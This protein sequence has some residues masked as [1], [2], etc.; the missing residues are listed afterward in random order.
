MLVAIYNAWDFEH[1]RK[2]V[3]NIKQCVDQVIIVWSRYS[4]FGVVGTFNPDLF[5]DCVCVQ[6]E[7]RGGA[8]YQKEMAKRNYGLER[9]RKMKADYFIMMD[10]DEF[11]HPDEVTKWY[12]YI[13]K[14]NLAGLVCKTKVYFKEPTLTIGDDTTYVTFIH[15]VN[16]KL[17]FNGNN[18]YPFT[19][20]DDIIRID[21]TRR[22]NINT[23]VELVDCYMH[24]YSWVRQDYQTKA[25]NSTARNAILKSIHGSQGMMS[26]IKQA[27]TNPRHSTRT[28]WMILKHP[29]K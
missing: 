29:S 15:K 18:N 10:C 3:D 25:F 20:V 5:K 8:A 24:H 2:S 21:P 23:G 22:L 4:N 16:H 6:H 26:E 17:R 13:K 19:K 11:Y 27:E 12:S 9:A 28:P 7:P 1:L 14:K